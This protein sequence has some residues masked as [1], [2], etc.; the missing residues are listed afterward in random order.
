[1]NVELVIENLPKDVL[2]RQ[3]TLD[4]AS[5]SD[6]ENARLRPEPPSGLKKGNHRRKVR[7]EPYGIKF[8][9]FE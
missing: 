6:D 3:L 1:M 5:S 2:Q 8:W 7:F 4:A 9:S